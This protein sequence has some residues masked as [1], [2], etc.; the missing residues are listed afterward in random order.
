MSVVAT[1]PFLTYG[2]LPTRVPQVL[3]ALLLARIAERWASGLH[4]TQGPPSPL[5]RPPPA[6]LD[7]PFVASVR[8]WLLTDSVGSRVFHQFG[9]SSSGSAHPPSPGIVAEYQPYRL[10][11]EYRRQPYRLVAEALDLFA[12]DNLA[13]WRWLEDQARSLGVWGHRGVPFSVSPFLHLTSGH[14][15]RGIHLNSPPTA[16][17]IR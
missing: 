2:C 16:L 9:G 1:L 8:Q 14:F 10:V 5:A 7:L 3:S 12:V 15:L 4:K 11:A 13:A 17:L 6:P